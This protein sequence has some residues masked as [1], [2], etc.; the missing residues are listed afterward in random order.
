[1]FRIRRFA[2]FAILIIVF[3]IRFFSHL[4]PAIYFF[5]TYF[6]HIR[7]TSFKLTNYRGKHN[8]KAAQRGAA[9]F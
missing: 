3:F 6:I 7:N 1:M 9:Y 2:A 8:L 5:V 4:Y